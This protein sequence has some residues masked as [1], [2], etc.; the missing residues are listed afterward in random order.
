M[1]TYHSLSLTAVA[2]VLVGCATTRPQQPSRA[3]FPFTHEDQVYEIVSLVLP[4][5]QGYNLLLQYEADRVVLHAEDTD[6]N[7]S[8]DSILVG[9]VTHSNAERIYASGLAAAEAGGKFRIE[10]PSRLYELSMPEG[11]YA[12]QTFGL[13]SGT[14]SNRL[15]FW[16]A[17]GREALVFVDSNGDGIIDVVEKGNATLEQGRR[18]YE[19]AL[20]WGQRDGRIERSNGTYVVLPRTS[21]GRVAI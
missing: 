9:D 12:V 14:V 18:I 8:I 21:T 10:E 4:D 17:R 6:Q 11:R 16:S 2:L 5:G 13:A 1:K 19:L 7:G 3:T 20:S 15:F